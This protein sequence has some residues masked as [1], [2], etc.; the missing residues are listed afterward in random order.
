MVSKI[1]NEWLEKGLSE[2]TK[3]ELQQEKISL[4]VIT[5]DEGD[6]RTPKPLFPLLLEDNELQPDF[7]PEYLAKLEQKFR[8]R[9]S[10]NLDK[11]FRTENLDKN[12]E[13]SEENRTFIEYDR[14]SIFLSRV[15]FNLFERPDSSVPKG[16]KEYPKVLERN[17][18]YQNAL[19]R[20]KK[21]PE[22]FI[23]QHM[24]TDVIDQVEK[25]METIPMLLEN[26]KSMINA[27]LLKQHYV[28]NEMKVKR[29]P[30]TF[31]EFFDNKTKFGDYKD[32]LVNITHHPKILS[33]FQEALYIT[34]KSINYNTY[35][36]SI[37]EYNGC[38]TKPSVLNN[39]QSESESEESF[40]D[41]KNAKTV[42][43][44]DIKYHLSFYFEKMSKDYMVTCI[45]CSPINPS[46]F[47]V[48]HGVSPCRET[49]HDPRGMVLCWNIHKCG[50]PEKA[51][52]TEEIVTCLQFSRSKPYLVVVGM[53]YGLI[54]LFDLRKFEK[55]SSVNNYSSKVR[56]IGA[57]Q[58]IQWVKRKYD[59]GK[60]LEVILSASMDGMIC[61]WTSGR[62]LDGSIMRY[63][64][65]AG[66]LSKEQQ[67]MLVDTVAGMCMQF[68]E[69]SDE[70]FIVGTIE[71]QALQ[72]DINDP[73][74]YAC[75]YDCHNGPLYDLQWSPLVKTIFMTTGTDRYIHIWQIGRSKPSKS[76]TLEETAYKIS[77]SFLKSTLFA[78]M[79]STK[80]LVFDLSVN[81]HK[82]IAGYTARENIE[83]TFLHFCRQNNWLLVGQ[84]D[85]TVDLCQLINIPELHIE[86]TTALK[87]TFH[88]DY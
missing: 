26:K 38:G 69:D 61:T 80:I 73:D 59:V 66:S 29:P 85:G 36:N 72:V 88:S 43:Q 2:S 4:P 57:I 16:S 70:I 1:I 6:I 71:G 12:R 68:Q 60:E 37:L 10:I 13:I 39:E 58:S 44:A 32:F 11:Y 30:K 33:R 76:L 24:Q 56:P 52:F 20:H 27:Y 9:P 48:G 65:R 35:K 3:E 15:I 25:Q 5:N 46:I 83:F 8:R 62:I 77:W 19:E 63:I 86:Q 53:R 87:N 74:S 41:G 45:E 81:L 51:F 14:K 78:A 21:F 79:C 22:I 67:T 18:L 82:E 34:E 54:S 50:Y 40:K 55:L 47:I 28:R 17:E 49:D 42:K 7:L 84:S 31:L 23:D 64:K 75:I